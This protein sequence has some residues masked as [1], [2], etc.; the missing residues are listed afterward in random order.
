[1]D[2]PILCPLRD[3]RRWAD[4]STTPI[5]R[6][7]PVDYT[8]YSPVEGDGVGI[9]QRCL[10][11]RKLERRSYRVHCEKFGDTFSNFD[12]VP[13]C[14]PQTKRQIC[15]NYDALSNVG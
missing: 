5:F 7:P 12:S 2:G 1:M 9:L 14:V 15:R 3:M 8:L 4:W 6:I 11:R 10:L 13:A